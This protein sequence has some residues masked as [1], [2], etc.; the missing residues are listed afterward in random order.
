MRSGV[1]PIIYLKKIT[2]ARNICKFI[3]VKCQILT[4]AFVKLEKKKIFE[5]IYV[6]VYELLSRKKKELDLYY[7]F[8]LLLYFSFR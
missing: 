8:L 2:P 3:V 1:K 7:P 5:Q 6:C 4:I